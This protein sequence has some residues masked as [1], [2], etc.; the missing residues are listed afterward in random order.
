MEEYTEDIKD[1]E[2][3]EQH[4]SPETTSEW[5]MVTK[6]NKSYLNVHDHQSSSSSSTA[7][8]NELGG[9]GTPAPPPPHLDW[10]RRVAYEGKKLLEAVRVVGNSA[11]CSGTFWSITCVAAAAAVLVAVEIRRRHRRPGRRSV[12]HAVCLLREKD[13]RIS[14]LLLQIAQL[15]EVLLSRRQVPVHRIG[16]S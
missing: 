8:T 4:P 1:W 12:D 16:N 14:Q 5:N 7:S 15:N 13:E 3:I 2:Q 11:V 6:I 9:T 10:W